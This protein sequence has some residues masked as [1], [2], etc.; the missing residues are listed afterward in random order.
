VCNNQTEF[1]LS[2]WVAIGISCL[3]LFVSYFSIRLSIALSIQNQLTSKAKECNKYIIEETQAFPTTAHEV[4][5]I[6][7]TIIYAKHLLD[8]QF[9]KSWLFLLGKSKQVSTHIF[10]FEL[11]TSITE[12]VHR[13]VL[14]LNPKDQTLEPTIKKQLQTCHDFLEESNQKYQV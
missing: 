12:Y 2:S 9:K 3:A 14:F 1:S 6:V 5:A 13:N 10:Y 11:H 7:S 8:L 4:S